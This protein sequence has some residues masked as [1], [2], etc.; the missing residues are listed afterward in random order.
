MKSEDFE[1]FKK[2]KLNAEILEKRKSISRMTIRSKA[3]KA[4]ESISGK[5]SNMYDDRS[6]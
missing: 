6:I 3:A 5:Q 2:D 4:I 1:K